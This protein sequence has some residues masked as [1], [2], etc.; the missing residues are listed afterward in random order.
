MSSDFF[1]HHD[2]AASEDGQLVMMARSGRRD[3]F[4]ELDRRYRERICRYLRRHVNCPT[5]AEEL[6]Q[7]TLIR[8]F[9]MLNQLRLGERIGAWLYRIAYRLMIDDVRK[10][11]Q[12]VPLETDLID[13]TRPAIDTLITEEEKLE[14]WQIA[15]QTLSRDGYMAIELRYVENFDIAEIAEIMGRSQISVRVLLHRARNRLLT[16]LPDLL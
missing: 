1:S 7:Q 13:T 3:A 11:R 9:E 16:Q 14:L 15:R 4:D 8:A 6:A 5:H 10:K 2:I 12:T